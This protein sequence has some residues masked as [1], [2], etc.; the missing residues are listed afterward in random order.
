MRVLVCG[1]IGSTNLGDEI[2][3]AGVRQL[4]A[5][6]RPRIAAVSSDP[7]RTRQVHGVTTVRPGDAARLIQAAR[8]ADLVVFGGGG[9]VQDET[10]ALNLP[11]HL[12]RL[13]PAIATRTPVVGMGLGVGP[14]NTG[15]GRAQAGLLRHFHTVVV[16]DEASVALLRELDVPALLGA[17]AA[18]HL[19]GPDGLSAL[20]APAAADGDRSAGNPRSELQGKAGIESRLTVGLRPW[21]G[22]GGGWLPVSWRRAGAQADWLVP[23]LAAALDRLVERSGLSLRM[24]AMQTDRDDALHQQVAAAMRHPVEVVVPNAHTVVPM[25]GSGRAAVAMRYHAGVSAT[26]MGRPSTLI[27]YSPKVDALAD[28]LGEGATRSAFDRDQLERLDDTVMELLERPNAEAEV[29]AARARLV[30]RTQV[31][32]DAIA[33]V[34]GPPPER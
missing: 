16:R 30:T 23:T 31:N 10:S 26:L 4:L 20:N 28:E 32:R 22:G 34:V 27:G 18:W 2:V 3:F 11:Y 29:E 6:W 24:V 25:M 9:L 33:A 17:D 5:P 13:L 12:A 21:S 15:L 19:A 7:A 1:W 8:E 14:L